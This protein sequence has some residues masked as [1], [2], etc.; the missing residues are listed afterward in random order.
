MSEEQEKFDP[1]VEAQWIEP[2]TAQSREINELATALAKAQGQIK[3]ALKDSANPFFDS[4]Y[5]G[6]QA[7]WDACRAPLSD[8]GLSIVQRGHS[9]PT[10]YV[11]R[12]TIMHSSGQ[13]MEGEVPCLT[14][15]RETKQN[16][17]QQLGSAITYARRYGL[18]AMVGV[19]P[20]EDED[21][22][23]GKKRKPQHGTEPIMGKYKKSEL[24]EKL[25]ALD[26]DLHA[27]EDMSTLMGVLHSY[28]DA[29]EQCERELP[30]WY[31]GKEGSDA[32][33]IKDRITSVRNELRAKEAEEPTLLDAG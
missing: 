5:A 31:Y 20:E 29:I 30:T 24:T 28:Q 4:T 32:P 26:A 12:T 18:A 25:R 2:Y 13:W 23:E 33:G 8:N 14:T 7:V 27:C 21:A 22:D 11:M 10:G 16:P 9:T 17:M 6:L 15:A 3:A 1:G 19:A